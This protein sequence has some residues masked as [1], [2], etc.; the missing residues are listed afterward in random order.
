MEFRDSEQLIKSRRSI[1]KW[2]QQPVPEESILKSIEL[3]TWAPNGGNH[4]N[5]K[6]LV[7]LNRGLIRQ[8]ADEVQS[9]IDTITSWPEAAQLAKEVQGWKTK[10]AF[11]RDAPACI[12]VLMSDYESVADQLLNLRTQEDPLGQ[13]LRE[14]RRF[15]N[16]GLQSVASA[17]GYLLLALHS[18]GLGGVWMTGPLLAKAEIEKLLKV[19]D[20]MNLIALVPLGVPDESPTQKR[21]A[22]SD[23]VQFYR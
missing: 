7:V 12:A 13:V 22:V 1:R 8:F 16:S 19:P 21:K 15:G 3:A 10:S 14:S 9:K 11:F 17:T 4:Q 5:W 23:V 20:E 18:Q 2:K 6:F